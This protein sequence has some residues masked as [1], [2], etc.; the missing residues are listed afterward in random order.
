[1]AALISSG[2]AS[3]SKVAVKST[4]LTVGTGTRNAMPVN[5]PCSSGMTRPTA[6]AAPVP[7]GTM[8][9]AAARASRR[10]PAAVSTVF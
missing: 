8:F 10:L 1:M 4:T 9:K 7:A 3:L 5:L 2:D 6:F